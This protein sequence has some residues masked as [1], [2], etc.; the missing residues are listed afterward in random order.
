M[1]PR[2]F[3]QFENWDR[4]AGEPQ[5]L[6]RAAELC[7]RE[8]KAWPDG[9]E[10]V[11]ADIEVKRPGSMS[12][13]SG[14]EEL[15]A[16]GVREWREAKEIE[17]WIRDYSLAVRF[18]R[19]AVTDDQIS[20][21]V[22]GDS[23]THVLGLIA[24]VKQILDRGRQR[25]A[26]FK[27]GNI[28]FLTGLMLFPAPALLSSLIPRCNLGLRCGHR[29]SCGQSGPCVRLCPRAHLVHRERP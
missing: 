11:E 6:V 9:G 5:D 22:S 15:K 10:R 19:L 29:R 17:V 2:E 13:Y 28:A 8:I 25:P 4:W 7:E 20:L 1:P 24:A 12:A 14:L 16:L 18:A 21:A 23:E 26:W 3:T 27:R